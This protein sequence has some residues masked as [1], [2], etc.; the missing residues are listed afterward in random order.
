[1]ETIETWLDTIPEKIKY[2]YDAM[3]ENIR[4]NKEG[5]EK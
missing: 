1:M 3:L 2:N 5:G 4:E